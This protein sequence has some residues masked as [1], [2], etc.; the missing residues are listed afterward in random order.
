V[1]AIKIK[2][3]KSKKKKKKKAADGQEEEKLE[4]L[5]Q[6]EGVFP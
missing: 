6:D 2:E 1:L 4:P 5:Q 3:L